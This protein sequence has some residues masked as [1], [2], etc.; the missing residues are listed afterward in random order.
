LRG[1]LTSSRLGASLTGVA[2]KTL[3]LQRRVAGRWQTLKSVTTKTGA[4]AGAYS[5]SVR[6][7]GSSRYRLVWSGVTGSPTRLIS[8]Q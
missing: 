5:C 1:T 2:G 8:L 6:P 4:S 7:T 3:T